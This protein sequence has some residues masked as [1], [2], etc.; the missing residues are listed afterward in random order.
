MAMQHFKGFGAIAEE[1]AEERKRKRGDKIR[2]SGVRRKAAGG[3]RA[4]K[5]LGQL[6]MLG[7]ILSLLFPVV[8]RAQEPVKSP[9][10]AGEQGKYQEVTDQKA[11]LDH[12][13]D[14]IVVTATRTATPLSD[15]P[16]S[17]SVVT[18]ED[19]EKRHV[20]SVDTALDLVPGLFNKH[21]KPLDTTSAVVLRGMPEQKRT[22]VLLDG[23]PMNDAYTGV[24]NWNGMLPENLD[25]VE[26]ARGPFSSL[27]GGNAMG[28]VIN[29]LTKMP[30]KR[31]INVSGGAGSDGLMTVYASYGDKLF[32][33]LGLF[34]SYGYQGSNGYASNSVVKTTTPGTTGT[35]V[36]GAQPSTT[37]RGAPTLVIGDTGDNNWY[38]DSGIFKLSYD[39]TDDSK[40]TF[41]FNRN[42]YGYGYKDPNNFLQT[43]GGNPFWSGSALF[44][45]QRFTVAESNFL[46]GEGSVTQNIYNAGFETGLFGKAIMKI[47]CGLI[48]NTSNWYTSA[49]SNARL[50]GG[51]GTLNETPSQA[52]TS[53]LQF[54]V[55]ILDKHL[56]I[57][58]GGY[59]YDHANTEVHNLTNW[60]DTGSKGSLTYEAGGK[61]NIYSLYSQ[62][63]I[64]LLENLKAYLG[65]RGDWWRTY[66][67]MVNSKGDA[68]VPTDYDSRTAF[69]LSPKGSLVYT[70]FENTTLRGSIGK[71]F[72]PPNV[73]ELYRT[74]AGTS[75]TYAANP[76]L[77]PET[78]ISGDVGIEQR[79]FKSAAFRVSYFYNRL[80]DLIY[81]RTM[82]V[83]ADGKTIELWDNAA[84]AETD[85]IEVEWDHRLTPW[86]RYFANY[87]YTHSKML[88]NPTNP[89]SVGKQLTGIPKNM[90]NLGGEVTYGPASL[91]LTG[92]YAS[93]RF[94]D[95][96]NLDDVNSVYGSHDPYFVADLNLRYAVTKN[97]ILAFAID[98]LFDE[99]Y[100]SY[101]QAPGRKFYGSLTF[102]F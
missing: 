88:D 76:M 23:Q 51:P 11:S 4:K 43:S 46:S 26:V 61:D 1:E 19:I 78:S 60:Q 44:N 32:K 27:Y 41:S 6:A 89:E 58:G 77:D 96:Q 42:H 79:L 65:L 21:A 47:S 99:D 36:T 57:V 17:V 20:Q 91:T 68:G 74:W 59:R 87:T 86:F 66:D 97:A 70:P 39:L 35:P 50:S 55:P 82:G 72:R 9:S 92:R 53:D 37:S 102:K 2:E 73:Y 30:T 81:R 45:G 48:D 94:A 7:L 8:G 75:T 64:A 40:A 13:F 69:D 28:G 16:A 63:E 54:S 29:I 12:T 84:S 38:R 71:A 5:L 100:F 25:R 33:R 34:A 52:F 95:D 49:S 98:N 10:A 56:L 67:G 80:H 62:V 85:G 90:F 18:K 24:V 93:K 22:L 14:E 3:E 31:E 15:V 83:G 101:Y